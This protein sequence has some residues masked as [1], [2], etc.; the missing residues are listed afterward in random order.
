MGLKSETA[1]ILSGG[2]ARAAYQVGVLSAIN[3]LLG[4]DTSL[5]FSILC[6]TS[7]GAIN[8]AALASYADSFQ[9]GVKEL[10]GIW[11]NFSIEQVYEPTAISLVKNTLP[12]LGALFLGRQ[13]R[14][15]PIFMLNNTPLRS[16]LER[17]ISFE[18]INQAIESKNLKA[19][20]ITASSYRTSRSIS[21]FQDDGALPEWRRHKRRGIRAQLNVDY[22]MASSAIPLIFPPTE[23]EGDYYCDGAVRQV[24]P[25]SPALHL[26]A[27]RILIIGV[28][29][30]RTSDEQVLS[31]QEFPSIARISS[32]V[33]NSAFLD[34]FE[35]DIEHLHT[36]NEAADRLIKCG[37][38]EENH[39]KKIEALTISPSRPL[40]EIAAEYVKD[41]PKSLR[42]LLRGTGITSAPGSSL[43]SYLLF[44]KS[45]SQRLIELG[46]ADAQ[47]LK[48]E[49]YNFLSAC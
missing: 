10:K 29:N 30:T 4:R 45:Y 17:S 33:L 12:I 19:I 42:F 8:A 16:L 15:K 14:N 23:I 5:P 39:L 43:A 21:F 41:L 49:L 20:G 48:V 34:M 40:D 38:A 28:S 13:I 3:D 37:I 44:E 46:Y 32:H 7:A 25:L 31:K 24:F 9:T 26:G 11:E 22:L 27:T 2:G 35:G 36:V 18:K 47:K 1:L 6:G